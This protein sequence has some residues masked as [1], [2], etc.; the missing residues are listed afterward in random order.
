M[1]I[2][3]TVDLTGN[4]YLNPVGAAYGDGSGAHTRAVGKIT[5]ISVHHDA[6]T[7]PHDYDSAA[8]YMQEA[9]GHYNRLG[10]GLQYH[11]KIDNTGTIF[12]IRPLTTWLYVVGSAENVSTVAIC[13]DGYF[14]P[15]VN[16]EPT[17]EQYEALVQLLT[18]LCEAHPEFPATWPDVRPHRDFSSTACCGDRLA[19]YIYSINSK[20]DAQR[21]PS[22]AVYDWPAL[23]PT[24]P[25]PTP[26][27][28]TP[29][30]QTPVYTVD[31]DF[32]PARYLAQ[33]KTHLDDIVTGARIQD[34]EPGFEV[35]FTKRLVKDGVG[36]LQTDYSSQ[37]FPSRAFPEKDF[38]L[39]NTSTTPT[40]PTDPVPPVVIPPPPVVEVPDQGHLE[41]RVGA[42]EA[43]WAGFIEFL[44]GLTTYLTDY[45]TKNK[46]EKK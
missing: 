8:R 26:P 41:D 13:L 35:D 21:I 37:K 44:A 34:Y 39:K 7:R 6:M 45:V 36:Y 24:V 15:T 4:S 25:V 38:L 32:K 1:K 5:S 33:V 43:L 12:K 17:R 42:L 10:P 19:P 27:P 22:N 14:H 46:K 31:L 30:E 11:Y 23:Q 29:P 9:A 40:D 28:V 2:Y 20:A 18:E 3:P 16:Q